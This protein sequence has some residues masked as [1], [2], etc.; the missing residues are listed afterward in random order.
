MLAVTY[1]TYQ[2]QVKREKT[3][4]LILLEQRLLVDQ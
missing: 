1:K 4:S 3:I 2:S